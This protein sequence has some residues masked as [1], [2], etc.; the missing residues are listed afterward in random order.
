MRKFFLV[1]FSLLAMLLPVAAQQGVSSAHVCGKSAFYDASASGATQLVAAGASIYVCGY[2]L[3]S[4][5][6]VNVGLA[7]SSSCTATLTKITPAFQLTAQTGMSDPSPFFR[8]MFVPQ[9]NALCIN[10]NGGVATQAIVY[11]DQ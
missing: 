10:T 1:L 2:V 11:Y 5:G 7:Y 3:F 9:G 6:T 4:A 8:G